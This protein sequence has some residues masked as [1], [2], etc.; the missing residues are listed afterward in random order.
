MRT[1]LEASAWRG[2]VILAES[3]FSTAGPP[4][5]C[6]RSGPLQYFED[7]FLM[8]KWMKT[9]MEL[10]K[11]WYILNAYIFL[12]LPWGKT[13]IQYMS[14]EVQK[15]AFLTNA[16]YDSDAHQHLRSMP[17][18]P[19]EESSPKW[20][21]LLLRCQGNVLSHLN[22][23]CVCHGNSYCFPIVGKQS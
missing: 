17:W 2:M 11:R 4:R 5:G 13:T 15:S 23:E 6:G 16:P 8:F 20:G 7:P 19:T 1:K 22:M 21:R 3:T 12:K 10:Q 18:I 9:K 14:R